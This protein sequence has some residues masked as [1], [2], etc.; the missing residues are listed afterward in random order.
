M[1]FL[2]MLDPADAKEITI[3]HI[4]LASKDEPADNVA[5]FK[6]VIEGNGIGGF[7][8]TYPTMHHGW[9]GSSADLLNEECFNVYT[10]G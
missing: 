1:A 10:Q 2:S 3:P 4:V 5:G 8:T 7:V 6:E 9:L